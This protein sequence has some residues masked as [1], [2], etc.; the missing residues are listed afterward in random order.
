MHGPNIELSDHPGGSTEVLLIN[1]PL[2]NKGGLIPA[3]P[4]KVEEICVAGHNSKQ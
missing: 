3:T 4:W 1:T 2:G